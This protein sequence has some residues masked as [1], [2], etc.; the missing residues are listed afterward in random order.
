[1]LK[2]LRN[3]REHRWVERMI[4]IEAKAIYEI[5]AAYRGVR[6]AN[7]QIVSPFPAMLILTVLFGAGQHVGDIQHPDTRTWVAM[8]VVI[9]SIP[10]LFRTLTLPVEV[11]T[12]RR[13]QPMLRNSA[14]WRSDRPEDNKGR[15]RV[16]TDLPRLVPY[17]TLSG[18]PS[19]RAVE[20]SYRRV[21]KEPPKSTVWYRW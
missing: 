6:G 1:M 11:R 21:G 10:L 18:Y 9:V 16:M 5:P 14:V 3:R 2:E 8:I 4:D 17:W 19:R 15:I 12:M 7:R 13:G 20:E